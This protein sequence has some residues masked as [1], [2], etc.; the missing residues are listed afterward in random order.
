MTPITA[1]LILSP[2]V[3]RRRDS[4]AHLDIEHSP[5][6]MCAM[7]IVGLEVGSA[8]VDQPY[9]ALLTQSKRCA[10]SRERE[11]PVRRLD[12]IGIEPAGIAVDCDEGGLDLRGLE[13]AEHLAQQGAA[14][15]R[16]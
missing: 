13:I 1:L 12:V 2:F 16:G 14:E 8:R 15:G 3:A 6:P 9:G 7:S 5:Y 4:L 11:D 10:V